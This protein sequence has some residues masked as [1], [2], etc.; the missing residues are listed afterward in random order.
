MFQQFA[1]QKKKFQQFFFNK[2]FKLEIN[3]RTKLMYN[4]IYKELVIF[5]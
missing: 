2:R 4:V 5:I 3:L 1:Y